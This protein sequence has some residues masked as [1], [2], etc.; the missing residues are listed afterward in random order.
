MAILG[1]QMAVLARARGDVSFGYWLPFKET[2]NPQ[3]LAVV[4][5]MASRISTLFK[6]ELGRNANI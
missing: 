5:L 2:S 1:R 4:R 3:I 6:A